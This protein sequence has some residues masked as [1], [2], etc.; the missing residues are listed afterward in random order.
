MKQKGEDEVVVASE[1]KMT[2]KKKELK[3]WEEVVV[4]GIEAGLEKMGKWRKE[5][6]D[7][8]VVAA[9]GVEERVG[10]REGYH[11]HSIPSRR[12]AVEVGQKAMG[13]RGE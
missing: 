2:M 9:A 6:K 5:W 7:E 8:E 1:E 10:Q 13:P 11:W 4:E 3:E 12:G